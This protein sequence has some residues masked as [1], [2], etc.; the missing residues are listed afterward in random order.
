MALRVLTG[1]QPGFFEENG[2]VVVSEVVPKENLDRLIRVMFD[3][4]EADPTN[5]DTWYP[6]DRKGGTLVYLHQHQAIWDNRQ[7][8]RVHGA[9]AD[10][11]GT[12][13]LWVSMDRTSLKP[14]IDPRFP[15]YED[16]GFVHWDMDTSKPFPTET[17]VQGVLALADTT[18]E[19][20]GFCCIPG[21]HRNLKEWIDAQPEGRDPFRPDLTRLPEGMKVTPIPM[22]AG[23][24]VIWNI[25]L[26]HGNGRNMG[27]QP[28]L[29]QYITMSRA[30]DD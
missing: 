17:H 15:H 16:R 25:L 29:A 4:L 27:D 18:E 30:R 6:K 13:K 2:Y 7:A 5:R 9:F 28:R 22:K 24:L 3:F 21:F 19:M 10:I 20:G 14:P 1:E 23:D 11:L 26:A 8:P 12:E